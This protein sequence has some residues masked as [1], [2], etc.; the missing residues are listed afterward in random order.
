MGM[1]VID[2]EPEFKIKSQKLHHFYINAGQ[3]IYE[4]E[5]YTFYLTEEE[6]I[7]AWFDNNGTEYHIT[8]FEEFKQLTD[9]L[10]SEEEKQEI[11]DHGNIESGIKMR[12][13]RR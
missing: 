4:Y 1:V 6:G 13:L 3:P 9:P 2:K 7:S 5:E 10:Q 11:I 8:N 12:P